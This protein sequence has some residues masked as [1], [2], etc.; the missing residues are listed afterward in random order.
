MIELFWFTW[1]D[2]GEMFTVEAFCF[3]SRMRDS[4]TLHTD[5]S[6]LEDMRRIPWF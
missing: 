4:V 5:A 2:I 3:P 6:C 1:S